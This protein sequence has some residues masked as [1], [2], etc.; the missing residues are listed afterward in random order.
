MLYWKSKSGYFQTNPIGKNISDFIITDESLFSIAVGIP[1]PLE[2]NRLEG[3]SDSTLVYDMIREYLGSGIDSLYQPYFYNQAFNDFGYGSCQNSVPSLIRNTKN[4]V[5][6][7]KSSQSI[8]TAMY[9]PSLKRLLC[10]NGGSYGIYSVNENGIISYL[11]S[12]SYSYFIIRQSAW[13]MCTLFISHYDDLD[14]LKNADNYYIVAS[15]VNNSQTQSQRSIEVTSRKLS[16]NDLKYVLNLFGDAA[17]PDSTGG[18]VNPYEPANPS[19]PS[20][21]PPGTFDDTSDPIPLPS[22]PSISAANTGFTRIYNPTLAQ[23]QSLARYLWTDESVITTIWN[24]IK[25]YFEDPMQAMIG[26]NLVPCPV[27]DAGSEEFVLMY[28]GTGVYMNVAANQFVDVDCG[29]VALERYYGSA[30]DQSPYTKVHCYLPYIGTVQL[31]TD[32]IM[33]TTLSVNYRVDIV[34]GSCVAS[35]L[36]D[37]NVLYQYSGHCAITIPFSSADFS[38]YVNAAIQVAKLGIT[39]AGNAG[40]AALAAMGEEASQ[41]T[42]RVVTR[43]TETRNTSRNPATGRQ[44]TRST[45]TVI[46]TT[47]YPPEQSQSETKASFAGLSPANISNTVGQIMSAKPNILH[48]GSFSGN[49]GYL[50]VRR[51]YLIIERPRMCL[52]ENYQSLN[53]YPSMITMT[54]GECVGYTRVQQVQLTGLWATNPEQAEILELLKM[55]VIF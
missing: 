32:E 9:I 38:N 23:V 25:Q 55:G 29:T 45:Q 36:V 39:A 34:S 31:D 15:Y 5:D 28:I 19:G 11:S 30:L 40:I 43:T 53:G 17:P 50:G 14:D 49:S 2:I 37:G 48:S 41:E 1:N 4:I 10:N 44:V 8:F 52:P 27:P 47:E 12:F 42:G 20:E 6:F 51:P 13:A 54:L 46:H 3:E 33:G 22:L 21:L 18:P 24:H 26:F 16:G 7:T 35:I